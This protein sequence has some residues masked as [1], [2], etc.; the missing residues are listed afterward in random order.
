MNIHE[1]NPVPR[2]PVK[3]LIVDDHVLFSEGL[4]ALL[5]N[6]ADL[7]VVGIISR[8]QDTDIKIQSL[9]PDLILM[10][11]NIRGENSLDK[12]REILEN[13]R[14]KIIMVTMY[15]QEKLLLEAQK[16]GVRGY[17]LKD[18]SSSEILR[19]IR[20]VCNGREYFDKKVLSQNDD[21]HFSK[22]QKLTFKEKEVITLIKKGLT[23]EEIADR[24]FLSALTIKTHRRNIYYKL[25]VTNTAELINFMNLNF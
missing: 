3:I 11:M 10:D 4:E 12:C 5:K 8:L 13:H 7:Q 22:N 15:N 23:N 19:C 1:S 24:L 9:T 20:E 14:V 16:T 25:G 18:S 17:L 6:E 21:D 2:F